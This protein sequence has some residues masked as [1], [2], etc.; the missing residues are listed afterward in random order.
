[1]IRQLLFRSKDERKFKPTLLAQCEEVAKNGGG[2]SVRKSSRGYTA[3][4]GEDVFLQPFFED[5]RNQRDQQKTPNSKQKLFKPFGHRALLVSTFV[6]DG[7]L[8]GSP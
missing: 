6:T 7:Q 2:H 4:L 1:M 5:R 8:S 3:R